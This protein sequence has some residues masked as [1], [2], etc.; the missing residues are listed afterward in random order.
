MS[1]STDTIVALSSPATGASRAVIRLSGPEALQICGLSQE[2][3]RGSHSCRISDA[4]ATALVFRGPKS[5]TSEDVV[6]LQLPG[7]P[8]LVEA[9][10]R[11]LQERGARMADPG[12]FT[13][14]AYLNGRLNLSEAEAVAD[15]IS[16]SGAAEVRAA[17]ERR[18]WVRFIERIESNL[19]DLTA[20][21]E[22]AIDFVGE[23]IAI[24]GAE[25][26]GRR[27]GS[28][29][30]ELEELLAQTAARHVTRPRPTAMLFGPANAGKSTLFNRLCG[31]RAIESEIA[32]TTRDML[33]GDLGGVDLLDTAGW[34]EEVT[35]ID[36]EAVRR[37]EALLEET[38]LVVLVVDATDVERGRMLQERA[39]GHAIL[40]VLNKCDLAA[41]EHLGARPW[42]R[43]SARTGAGVADLKERILR[44]LS[45][46][47]AG[48]GSAR[49]HVNQRQGSQ[50]CRARLALQRGRESVK[51]EMGCEFTALEL[52]EALSALGAVTGRDVG[53]EIIDR[54]F[55][56]FCL[57]K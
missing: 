26:T 6:E 34:M 9:A 55:S 54:I 16:S 39:G 41:S 11:W 33:R 20:D 45:S 8:P 51:E 48:S 29:L 7:S 42:L 35:G 56:R 36:A 43:V 15:L 52:R 12:E 5:Y 57:G 37:T 25:E 14:R 18:E 40:G 46:L 30:G 17:L 19:L 4:L 22:A 38:D 10:L 23:D 49:F 2:V 50:L 21:V 24:I 1:G 3:T 44:S 31:T 13:Q 27:L 28:V 32:G 53:E 47:S